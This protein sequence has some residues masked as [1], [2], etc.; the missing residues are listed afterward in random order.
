MTRLILIRHA[1]TAE[2][3]RRLTGRLPG[4]EISPRGRRAAGAAA[5]HLAEEPLAAVYTSPVLRCRQTAALVAAP[6]GLRPVAHGGLTEIDYG[7]WAGRP[8]AA[9]RR[10][11]AWRLLQTTPARFAFPEGESLRAA[12]ARAVQ[13]AEALAGR[14][15]GSALA[16]V[17]HGDVV[18]FI[19]A[20]HLGVPLDLYSRLAVD[21]ASLSILDLPPH[22]PPTLRE[23]NLTPGGT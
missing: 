11:A 9:L 12:Q 17:T 22:G 15:P 5:R 14:H 18:R 8:L 20:H 3:G 21:P 19:L 6:H 10:T 4:V 1:P 13:A 7:A 23:L 2:T 16:L